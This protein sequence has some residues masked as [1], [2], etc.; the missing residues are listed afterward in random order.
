MASKALNIKNVQVLVNYPADAN[1]LL[2]HHRVLLYRI[3]NGRWVALTP[4]EEVL[5]L[6]LDRIEHQVLE[7]SCKFPPWSAGITY[8][9]DEDQYG[10]REM[11]ELVRYAK[12]QAAVLSADHV[13]EEAT[14]D[15]WMVADPGDPKFGSAVPDDLVSSDAFVFLGDRGLVRWDGSVRE[16]VSVRSE[17]LES[18][19]T[20][21]HKE[22]AD[23]RVLGNFVDSSGRRHLEFG[24][25]IGL[26]KEPPMADWNLVGPRVVREFL[27]NVLDGPG[28]LV[29]YHAEWVRLSGVGESSSQCH[30]HRH[31]CEVL[32]LALGIDQL[33]VS[34]C[35]SFEQ[36]TRRF[37]QL[38]MAVDRCPG[39]PDF[40]G[41]DVLTDGAVSAKGAARAPKFA[42]WISDKQKERAAVLKGHKE[43]T[44]AAGGRGRDSGSDDERRRRP[45]RN[46]Q[47]KPG[48]YSEGKGGGKDKD[49]KDKKE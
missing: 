19:R 2:W 45:A 23:V 29:S 3:A 39:R 41:L 1:G 10:D 27:Q 28:N 11:A 22:R 36:T 7:R 8:S 13:E 30:E 16:C 15:K 26:L 35:A 24:R 49:K 46:K 42:A 48:A 33:D 38:E 40:V 21:L 4:D 31:L 18:R 14:V 12:L 32:R 37:A 9:F 34:S 44:A 6:D 20:E 47:H 17:D 25:A 5:V 43:F